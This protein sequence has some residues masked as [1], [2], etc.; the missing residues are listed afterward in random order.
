MDKKI[1]R[2][3]FLL[4]ATSIAAL[5]VASKLPKLAKDSFSLFNKEGGANAYSNSSYGGKK[6]V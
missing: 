5:F 1:T 2:K 4:S 3:E 6:I